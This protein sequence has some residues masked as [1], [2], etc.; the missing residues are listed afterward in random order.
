MAQ[1]DKN[2]ARSR[3]VAGAA[4]LLSRRGMNGTSIRE[5]AK[6]SGA[7]LGSTYHY[8]PGGKQQVVTE[9]VQYIGDKVTAGLAHALKAGPVSGLKAFLA[10]WREEVVRSDFRAGCPVLS[11]AVE[12]PASEEEMAALLVAE[13]VFRDWMK[14]LSASLREHGVGKAQ[15]EAIATLVV[16]SVEGTIALCRAQR[17][18]KPLDQVSKQLEM[19]I[20]SAIGKD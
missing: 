6:H 1:T 4:D 8:F 15:A 12:E 19:V 13:S 9:A 14:L 2:A 7:P 16:A 20:T 17:S 3:L 5:L 11:V 18:V 10:I